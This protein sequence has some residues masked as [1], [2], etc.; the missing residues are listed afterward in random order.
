MATVLATSCSGDDADDENAATTSA[1]PVA[2]A[3]STATDGTEPPR[4]GPV[5]GAAGDGNGPSVEDQLAAATIPPSP[6]DCR[7]AGVDA[8]TEIIG[9]EVA[10]TIG[11]FDPS[12]RS[13]CRYVDASETTLVRV[14]VTEAAG[15]PTAA[16]SFA[17]LGADPAAEPIDATTLRVG[18]LAARFDGS[19]I[20]VTVTPDAVADETAAGDA[21]V[22]LLGVV[23]V[24]G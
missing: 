19:L 15:D 11:Q 13:L 24:A 4:P 2:T 9:T 3:E 18:R 1:T 16:D 21:A 23:A 10:F 17:E 22:A 12:G 8:V 6:E 20:E 14:L 7:S 5:P